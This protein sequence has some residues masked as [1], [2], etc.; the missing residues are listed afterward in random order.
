MSWCMQ[1]MSVIQWDEHPF[2]NMKPDP[3]VGQIALAFRALLQEDMNP[4]LNRYAGSV[5]CPLLSQRAATI[6]AC[7]RQMEMLMNCS[8]AEQM[9]LC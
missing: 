1:V 3:E 4:T 8:V 6:C 9:L 2:L 5:M 7:S